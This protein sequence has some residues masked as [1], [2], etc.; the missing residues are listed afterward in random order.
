MDRLERADYVR[1]GLDVLSDSGAGFLTISELCRRLEVTKGS[2]YHHFADM[3]AFVAALL[4]HW[5]AEH[6]HELIARS[7]AETDPLTRAK[8]L[9]DIAV[10][11]P[12]GAEASLRAWGRSNVDVARVMSRVDAA[13]EQHL[14]AANEAAGLDEGRARRL[15]NVA[16]AI[17]IGAQHRER[18]V[19]R[20][21]LRDMLEETLGLVLGESEA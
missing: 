15:A 1:C 14:T 4:E 9:I 20:Q 16:M 2:F 19:D 11:L 17:L 10:E 8:V 6:S 3:P 18:P 13:R 5:E 21:Q 12:H 7:A